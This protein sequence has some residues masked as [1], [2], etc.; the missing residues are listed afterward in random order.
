MMGIE[1][2]LAE[3]EKRAGVKGDVLYICVKDFFKGNPACTAFNGDT[4]SFCIRFREFRQKPRVNEN[5]HAVFGVRCE[6][7]E[8][9]KL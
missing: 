5:G 2:R 4:Y 7:C 8:G 6:G 1:R 9:V 3:V